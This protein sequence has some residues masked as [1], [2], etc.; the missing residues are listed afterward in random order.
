VWV[1]LGSLLLWWGRYGM[2]WVALWLLRL[3]LGRLLGVGG[4]S[5][6][7]LMLV[8]L[9]VLRLWLLMMRIGLDGL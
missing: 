7:W 5:L 9:R 8:D 6:L 1:G 4:C 3:L 2:V